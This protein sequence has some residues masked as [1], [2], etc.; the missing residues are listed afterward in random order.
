MKHELSF[1]GT[2]LVVSTLLLGSEVS[3]AGAWRCTDDPELPECQDALIN[4]IEDII[5][6]DA[7]P[8]T[9]A[10]PALP[11]YCTNLRGG[12][13]EVDGWIAWS[14]TVL[15]DL[16]SF[17]I[18]QHTA[19]AYL[20]GSVTSSGNNVGPTVWTDTAVNYVFGESSAE[21]M[22]ADGST[23]VMDL[24]APISTIATGSFWNGHLQVI[25]GVPDGQWTC[26]VGYW[27]AQARGTG[28]R[29]PGVIV[30]YPIAW[31]PVHG[32]IV[33]GVRE[34]FRRAVRFAVTGSYEP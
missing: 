19:A 28:R 24:G 20:S 34:R 3:H 12:D 21:V 9:L 31:A 30:H 13:V 8:F 23:G 10:M 25:I 1:L 11:Y 18:G 29:T 32:A 6:N 22:T 14:I 17:L 27:G 16:R 15:P 4:D 7:S 5:N 26:T 33:D 2:A